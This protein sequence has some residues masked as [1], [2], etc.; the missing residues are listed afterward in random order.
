MPLGEEVELCSLPACVS[1]PCLRADEAGGGCPPGEPGG[2]GVRKRQRQQGL[3]GLGEGAIQ[4]RPGQ[5]G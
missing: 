3:M 1:R 5:L 4:V 2:C